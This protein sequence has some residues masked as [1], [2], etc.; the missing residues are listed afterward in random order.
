MPIY[1]GIR[2]DGDIGVIPSSTNR[3]KDEPFL[4]CQVLALILLF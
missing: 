2:N 3:F 4:S 1:Y